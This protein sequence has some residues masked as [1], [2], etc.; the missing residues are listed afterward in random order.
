MAC[1]ILHL[2]GKEERKGNKK[3]GN[4]AENFSLVNQSSFGYKASSLVLKL[5]QAE[6]LYC[7]EHMSAN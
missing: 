7:F 2:Y 1:R 5:M 4:P 3:V 6:R